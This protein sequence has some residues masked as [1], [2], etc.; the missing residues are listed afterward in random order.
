MYLYKE[1]RK[2][3]QYKDKNQR[4]RYGNDKNHGVN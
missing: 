1:T 4:N 2:S 3:E